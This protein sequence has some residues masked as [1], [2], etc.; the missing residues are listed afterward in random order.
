MVSPVSIP[1]SDA[2][3]R[4][5]SERSSNA[6]SARG[7]PADGQA[8]E[9]QGQIR[10]ADDAI[11]VLRARLEQRLQQ[12]LGQGGAQVS[13]SAADAFEP[14][15]ASDVASRVLGFVQN[16]LEQEARNGADSERL[17]GLLE[18]ARKGVS[19]GF[20]EARD[21]IEAL[22]MMNDD[23]SADIDDSFSRIQGGLDDLQQRYL[24]DGG[25]GETSSVSGYSVE[26]SSRNQLSFQVR[27]ADGD[28][29]T[30][31]M[32]EARYAGASSRTEQGNGGAS[33]ESASA[34]L[35]AG[36]YQFSVQGELDDGERQALTALFKDV[37]QVAG[38]FF[39]GDVQSA[40]SAAGQLGL[41]GEELASFSLNLS[42]VRTVRASAYEAVSGE[43]S[44]NSQLRPLAGLAQD[45][46][47]LADNATRQGLDS[48]SL[49]SLM[50]R[51]ISDLQESRPDALESDNAGL[52]TDF[53][54]TIIGALE[55]TGNE[56]DQDSQGASD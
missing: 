24:G 39:D 46:Q 38:Q 50:D 33:S 21:Q 48:G 1:G 16:R 32:D 53:W 2:N 22:G 11:G 40:F 47:S 5:H 41:D 35:F 43:P 52:M 55:P 49:E 27:T 25:A 28:I 8:A 45:V 29:V 13:K 42:S 19:Q 12:G 37:Q 26:A 31:A 56:T 18:Q 4:N 51:M 7:R 17:S 54:K 34:S 15:S 20:S 3:Y 6:S 23:L 9:G 44:T 14:P 30:V 10:S 36:R